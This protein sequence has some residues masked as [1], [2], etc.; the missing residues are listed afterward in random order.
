MRK[1]EGRREKHEAPKKR[2]KKWQLICKKKNPRQGEK[3][4]RINKSRGRE[5]DLQHDKRLDAEHAF[6]ELLAV[7][8]QPIDCLL[9]LVPVPK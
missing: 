7:Q 1:E 6:A 2:K 3:K 9:Q 5:G 4:R 8:M